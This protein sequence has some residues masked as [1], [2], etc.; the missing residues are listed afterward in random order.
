MWSTGWFGEGPFASPRHECLLMAALIR[1]QVA[2][3][4]VSLVFVRSPTTLTCCGEHA[5]GRGLAV[6]MRR[7][8]RTAPSQRIEA[9]ELPVGVRRGF[10]DADTAPKYVEAGSG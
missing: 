8:A 4:A 3:A 7:S 10:S 9:H 1:R 6:G 2:A 5:T